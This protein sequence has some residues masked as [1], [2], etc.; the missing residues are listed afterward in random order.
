MLS[1]QLSP[2]RNCPS[3]RVRVWLRVSFGVGGAIFLG[4]NCPRTMENS[5][6]LPN[7][8]TRNK[9]KNSGRFR[10]INKITV[11]SVQV[12]LPIRDENKKKYENKE[13]GSRSPGVP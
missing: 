6:T 8:H 9:G 12:Y 7:V 2:E 1:V 13:N 3:A 10:S 11:I 5:A 4:D